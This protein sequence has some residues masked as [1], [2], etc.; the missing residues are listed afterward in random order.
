MDNIHDIF[1]KF[2][3][4]E[5]K[6][7]SIVL[8]VYNEEACLPVMLESLT[9][10][11]AKEQKQYN[12]EI[13]FIDDFS[14]DRSFA[15][16]TDYSK[17]S[18]ENIRIAALQLSKNSGSHIAITAGL[19]ISRADF[20]IIMASD[21]QDPPEVIDTLIK[22]WENGEK[23]ILAARAE[24]LDHSFIGNLFSKAA[25]KIMNW[26]TGIEMPAGGCDM[27]GVDKLPLE[28]FN[29]ID[30]R[31]TTFIYRLLSLGYSPK[32]VTY[33]K[34]ERIGGQSKWTFIKKIR[35]LLD[36]VTGYSNRPLRLIARFSLLIF[37][38]LL[39]RWG[40]VIFRLLMSGEEPDDR[41]VILN[42]IFTSLAVTTLILSALGDYIW[43][44][45]DE[46]RKRPVY[47]F[48]KVEGRIFDETK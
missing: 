6:R 28:A 19:N 11:L 33:T 1:T 27:L 45:L 32:T 5:K 17:K 3:P 38:V 31:N 24:N 16:L 21:G 41:T 26:A 37:L 30:E 14:K 43:R 8:P 42:S 23:I 20:T 34:R 25:W 15:I 12:W 4:K 47:H 10:Y 44:I 35:I 29:K 13:I 39:I 18:F 2:N 46:T 48:G 7:L 36:A 40:F 22:H 9:K